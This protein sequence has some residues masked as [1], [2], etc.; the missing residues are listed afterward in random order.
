MLE[1]VQINTEGGFANADDTLPALILV[2]L[3]ANPH[4]LYSN[5]EYIF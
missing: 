1:L 4:R 5:I 2:L 3:N